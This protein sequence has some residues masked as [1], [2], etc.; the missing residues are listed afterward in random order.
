MFLG[1]INYYNS[2]PEMSMLNGMQDLID[3][4]LHRFFRTHFLIST[5]AMQQ[6]N[7]LAI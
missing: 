6:F 3:T 7:S 1:L 5:K 2:K 4:N